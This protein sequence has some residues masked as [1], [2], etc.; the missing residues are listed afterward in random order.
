MV[1]DCARGRPIARLD[2]P[3]D[4]HLYG[5]GCFSADGT[6]LSTTGNDTTPLEGRITIWDPADGH[7]RVGDIASGG[8]GSH[9]IVRLPETG[10]LVVAN[11]GIATHPDSG[12][13]PLNLPTMRPIPHRWMRAGTFCAGSCSRA[14]GVWCRSVTRRRMLTA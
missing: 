3:S 11:G 13:A 9:E 2:P 7:A 5:H 14:S 8:I 10:T 6:V 12:R 1:V 4:R